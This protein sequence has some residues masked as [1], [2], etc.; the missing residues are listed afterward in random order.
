MDNVMNQKTF[1]LIK[2]TNQTDK[3]W[4]VSNCKLQIQTPTNQFLKQ[5]TNNFQQI[6]PTHQVPKKKDKT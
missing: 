4:Q 1:K 3:P 2:P 6:H 5:I